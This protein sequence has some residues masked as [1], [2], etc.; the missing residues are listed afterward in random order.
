MKA[1]ETRTFKVQQPR[2]EN[3]FNVF[4]IKDNFTANSKVLLKSVIFLNQK[5]ILIV[6]VN[7]VFLFLDF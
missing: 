4:V 2:N 3:I 6:F 1:Y 5:G 7:G